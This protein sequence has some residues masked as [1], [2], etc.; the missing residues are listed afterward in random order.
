MYSHTLPKKNGFAAI[1]CISAVMAIGGSAWSQDWVGQKTPGEIN[2]YYELEYQN[3]GSELLD[4]INK[5]YP[6]H[7]Q[8]TMYNQD[9]YDSA[10]T[11]SVKLVDSIDAVAPQDTSVTIDSPYLL[12]PQVDRGE[13]LVDRVDS[14]DNGHI[15]Q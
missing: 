4:A 12:D 1:L 14:F 10:D 7:V 9:L 15:N 8:G 11:D 2:P 3:S 5:D 13:E 6:M